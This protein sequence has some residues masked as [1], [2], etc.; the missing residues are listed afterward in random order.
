[1]SEAIF[2]EAKVFKDRGRDEGLNLGPSSK[3]D[4]P[5]PAPGFPVSGFGE[6][7]CP[8]KAEERFGT[9]SVSI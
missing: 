5:F 7:I 6:K 4:S 9:G 2:S 8:K 3:P 1:M